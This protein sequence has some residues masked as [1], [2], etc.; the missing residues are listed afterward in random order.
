[1]LRSWNALFL[2]VLALFACPTFAAISST[3][4]VINEQSLFDIRLLHGFLLGANLTL[5]YIQ[6]RLLWT[7]RHR[8]RL[9][10]ALFML[11]SLPI[12]LWP[13]AGEIG[14]L[15]LGLLLGIGLVLD[16]RCQDTPPLTDVVA[17]APQPVPPPPPNVLAAAAP[18]PLSSQELEERARQA[19]AQQVGYG[20][21]S[22]LNGVL[23]MS[24]L[25]LDMP[26]SA[27]QRD[28]VQTIHNAG[29]E[30]LMQFNNFFDVQPLEE[31][32]LTIEEVQID[33][34]ALLDDCWSSVQT[35]AESKTVQIIKQMHLPPSY[36]IRGDL[37]LLRCIIIEMLNLALQRAQA[38]TEIIF[39]TGIERNSNAK[40]CQLKLVVKDSGPPINKVQSHHIAENPVQKYQPD[41]FS[42]LRNCRRW[43][44]RIGGQFDIE[45]S[46][47]GVTCCF[48]LPL[49]YE[50]D[51]AQRPAPYAI[52]Q[53]ASILIACTDE[54]TRKILNQQ[55]TSWGMQVT[56]TE[57]PFDTLALLRIRNNLNEPFDMLLLEQ[58][59]PGMSGLQLATRIRSDNLIQ[60][61]LPLILLGNL[62]E[63]QRTQAR[64][65]EISCIVAKPI[66]GYVLKATLAETLGKAR[67]LTPQSQPP[68]ELPNADKIRVLVAEDNS[69]A[70]KVTQGML[71]RLGIS[72]DLAGDGAEALEIVKHQPRDTPYDLILMDC[73]MPVMDG[74]VAT[75]QL[76]E[77]E[78]AQSRP[79]TP[80]LAL[81]AH[82]LN[83]YREHSARSGMDGHIPKPVELSQLRQA[84]ERWVIT[85]QT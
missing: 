80:V 14:C 42:N 69:I 74:F 63:T 6:W 57:K 81:T 76:R 4:I 16:W 58:D 64:A 62:S 28:Y 36:H 7:K 46:A 83:E 51:A 32:S 29:S 84:I 85:R 8:T 23:G 75:Q 78:T 21:R 10:L 43:T 25:L 73:E 65:A 11:I 19:L 38:N 17:S 34:Q 1:M 40:L 56:Q 18:E 61:A 52:L 15:L 60:R 30:L 33:M 67:Q 3:N 70:T 47:D 59:M 27:R 2:S 13:S 79:R 54:T 12:G 9:G 82:A 20:I 44:H 53:D 48:T 66:M 49:P 31:D 50:Q 39:I 35:Y 5:S 24:E 72:P 45:N 22:P 71:R 26:L 55:C 68:A 77:W 41:A 37:R